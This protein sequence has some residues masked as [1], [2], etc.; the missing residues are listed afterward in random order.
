M[1]QTIESAVAE[2]LGVVRF[3]ATPKQIEVMEA[4]MSG[5]NR[6]IAMG[7][8]IRGTKTFGML[9][10]LVVLCKLFPGSRWAIVRTDLPTLRRNVVPSV[11]KIRAMGL[12]GEMG[13]L[14]QSIWTWTFTNGSQI[15]LFPES[16]S[17]DPDLERWKGLEVNG[18]LLEEASELQEASANKAIERAGSWIIPPTKE[19]PKPEQ[20]PPFV[21]F[22]FNPTPNWPKRWF[23]D[24]WK[25][26]SLKEPFA[27]IP[28]TAKDNP[29]IPEAV[30]ESWLNLPP[31][32]YARF[33]EGEWEFTEDPNQLIKAEWIWKA[34]EIEHEPGTRKLGVD[35]ARFGD[36]FT[37]LCH[38]DGNALM[39]IEEFKGLSIDQTTGVVS[40]RITDPLAPVDPRMVKVDGVGLGA[41]VVDNLHAAGFDVVDVIS[42]GKPIPRPNSVFKFKNLRSQMWWEL[43]EALRLGERSLP[44]ELADKLV[45]DLTAIRYTITA[46]KEVTVESKDK[47]KKRLGRSTDYGDS[48]VYADFD[49]PPPPKRPRL[50][51]THVQVAYG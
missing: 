16:Y 24:K 51:G 29:F 8:G 45:G 11:N 41:G 4:A 34:R 18:F 28:A 2:E 1:V 40:K 22:T 7:G 33:V 50:P 13:E 15:L 48:Y 3:K 32:E 42:G 39:N 20:P 47:I 37:T 44:E 25:A 27:F 36:D 14:N 21:F 30:W 46:D 10:I 19:N 49:F 26:G 43:R 31:E 5:R 12:E 6:Y 35:V 23:W 38:M 9:A 17:K